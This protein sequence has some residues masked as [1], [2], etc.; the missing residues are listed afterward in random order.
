MNQNIEHEETP[1][2]KTTPAPG[3]GRKTIIFIVSGIAIGLGILAF[4]SWVTAPDR[5]NPYF[6]YG[7]GESRD[8]HL[9]IIDNYRMEV[10]FSF[11]IA[12]GIPEVALE[13]SGEHARLPG[14]SL[15]DHTVRVINGKASSRV[16]IL[17]KKK[18]PLKAG[19]HKLI[20]VARDPRTDTIVREGR[21]HFNY[22][23][24]EV[25]GKCSC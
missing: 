23:M 14:I 18:P 19:T 25:I 15:Y 6:T 20:V 17:F 12:P 16:I 8:R 10:P 2:P 11:D 9:N 7:T 13:F 21:I 5:G 24:D 1:A 3:K 4:S 22:N